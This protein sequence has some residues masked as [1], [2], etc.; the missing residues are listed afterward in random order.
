MSNN[1]ELSIYNKTIIIV[2][3][4]ND[5]FSVVIPNS[6]PYN[7]QIICSDIKDINTA[8]LVR[9]AYCDGHYDGR[10]EVKEN[11]DSKSR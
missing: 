8:K 4:N 5:T 6:T 11:V 3:P 10:Q 1:I 7:W 9:R 2:D